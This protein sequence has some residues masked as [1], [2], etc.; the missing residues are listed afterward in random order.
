MSDIEFEEPQKGI[1]RRTVTKAM[2]WAVPVIAVAAPVPAFAVSGGIIEFS[3][4]GCKLPGNS[5]DFYKGYI[6]RMTAQNDHRLPIE[7]DD[8]LRVPR[9][10]RSRCRHSHQFRQLHGAR[11]PV[12]HSR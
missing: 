10:L 2:A 5:Q 1:S 4:D 12:H 8:Q 11:Q 7:V 3:G 9:R 6:F